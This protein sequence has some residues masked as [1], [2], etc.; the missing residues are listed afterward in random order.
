MEQRLVTMS[1]TELNRAALMQRIAERRTTQAEVARQL[2]MSLRQVERMYAAFKRDGAAALASKRRGRPSNRKLS[3]AYKHSVM[4]LV[5]ERY[6]D[7]GPTL[8]CEKLRELHGLTPSVETLRKWMAE[9][10]LWRTR[11]ERH[12]SV[13]L[14][15]RGSELSATAFPKDAHIKPGAIVENK[16]LGHV[17]QVI[18]AAQRERT[19]NQLRAKRMTLRR[20]DQLR[21]ALGETGELHAQH[22]RRPRPPTYPSLDLSKPRSVPAALA[23]VLEW[24]KAQVPGARQRST[25]VLRERF[26]T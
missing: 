10:G 13:V 11:R 7:F 1:S 4:T 2:G 25:A 26:R 12:G 20:T 23:D 5:R 15:Y 17:L 18:E 22:G 6:A 8:A 24:V 3:D 16:R 9:D 14:E 21:K 19:E